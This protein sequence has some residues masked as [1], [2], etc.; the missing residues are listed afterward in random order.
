[1]TRERV[2]ATMLRGREE[3]EARWRQEDMLIFRVKIES[4]KLEGESMPS[5]ALQGIRSR[6][7][8]C[9]RVCVCSCVC[10]CGVTYRLLAPYGPLKESS[11]SLNCFGVLTH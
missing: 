8:V 9:V 3:V 6:V 2:A 7:C 11:S 5:T 4:Q 1:V 10:V